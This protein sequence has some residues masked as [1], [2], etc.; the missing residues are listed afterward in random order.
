MSDEEDLLLR[1]RSY[2]KEGYEWLHG[3][4]VSAGYDP[5]KENAEAFAVRIRA[6]LV[7]NDR[8]AEEIQSLKACIDAALALHTQTDAYDQSAGEGWEGYCMECASEDESAH[9]PCPNVRALLGVK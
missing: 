7:D 4:L 1:D 2:Y 8:A 3:V 9:W 5:N 6:V